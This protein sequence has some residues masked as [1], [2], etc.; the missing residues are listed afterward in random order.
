MQVRSNVS[1]VVEL[2]RPR[3][4][5]GLGLEHRIRRHRLIGREHRRVD[6]CAP[7]CLVVVGLV[8]LAGT[9]GLQHASRFLAA[10][11]CLFLSHFRFFAYDDFARWCLANSDPR[12]A[13]PDPSMRN[14]GGLMKTRDLVLLITLPIG[15]LI[16]VSMLS[17]LADSEM[18]QFFDHLLMSVIIAYGVV[19]CFFM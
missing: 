14:L 9:N 4:P 8:G 18:A 6:L 3:T 5:V 13:W 11:G 15:L 10:S 12:Y 7:R 17:G 1:E 16:G 2:P 19:Y